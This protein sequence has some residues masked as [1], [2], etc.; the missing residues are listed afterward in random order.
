M[1][2][3]R[4]CQIV[5]APGDDHVD[6]EAGLQ[7]IDSRQLALFDAAVVRLLGTELLTVRIDRITRFMPSLRQRV[8]EPPLRLTTPRRAYDPHFDLTWHLRR[9]PPRPHKK[10]GK[11]G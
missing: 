3:T 7:A 4:D 2:A 10:R 1:G 5:H 8:I 6:G 11:Q 9:K